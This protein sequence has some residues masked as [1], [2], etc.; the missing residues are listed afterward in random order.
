MSKPNQLQINIAKKTLVKNMQKIVETVLKKL[1]NG[2][3]VTP[4]YYGC[5]LHVLFQK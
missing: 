4:V 2:Y 1:L 3:S 5:T